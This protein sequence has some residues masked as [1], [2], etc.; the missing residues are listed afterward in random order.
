M[1][2]S[3][4]LQDPFSYSIVPIVIIS[5]V[6]LAS[7]IAL[8]TIL[9]VRKKKNAPV[10]KKVEPVP[11][12]KIK[13]KELAQKEYLA[14]IAI[15]EQNYLSGQIDARSAHQELSAIVRMF[16][17]DLTGINAQNFS[18]NELK[19]HNIHQ[20]SYLIEEFYAPEFAERSDKETSNSIAQAREVII[21]WN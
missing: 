19:A 10:K 12:F 13:S 18:L 14:K 11:V 21:R 5:I 17:H 8:I 2:T 16:V 9:L 20:I 1:Q 7:L 4:E 6:I 3:V 15:V